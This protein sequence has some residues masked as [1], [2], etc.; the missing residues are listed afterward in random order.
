MQACLLCDTPTT[1]VKFCSRKCAVTYNNSKKPKRKKI[2]RICKNCGSKFTKRRLYCDECEP[3][4]GNKHIHNNLRL[5]A[6]GNRTLSELSQ[7]Q[8]A[9]GIHRSWWYSELRNHCR[10]VNQSRP[11]IC[12]ICQ[13]DK[14]IEYAHI[15]PVRSFSPE[16]TLNEINDPSNVLVL[17][18]NHHWEFDNGLIPEPPMRFERM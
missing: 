8:I 16:T 9:N 7:A 1:N 12:Q 2:E 15:K 3:L 6:I 11:K 13:Y 14:H 18:P 4:H 5:E 17:C 10:C